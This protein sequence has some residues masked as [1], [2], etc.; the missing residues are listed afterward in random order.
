MNGFPIMNGPPTPPRRV[1]FAFQLFSDK[2][3]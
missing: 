3:L 1:F 2:L